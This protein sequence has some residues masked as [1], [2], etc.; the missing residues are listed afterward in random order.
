MGNFALA[1]TFILS[2]V[3]GIGLF[4][5]M[6]ERL[7]N[8]ISDKGYLFNIVDGIIRLVVFFLY[9]IVIS[10]NKNITRVF[11][12]HG[13]E[14]KS[15]HAYEA[16]EELTADNAMKYSPL[17]PRCGTAFLLTVMVVGIIVFSMFGKPDSVLVRIGIRLVFIPLIA[18]FSYEFIKF[19]AKRQ[20]HIFTRIIMTPG[21]WLQRL[22]TREPS[23]DQVQ[24]A[25]VSLKGV[26][27]MEGERVEG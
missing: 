22:T 9:I 10:F 1:I 26:L 21:L 5:I 8:I 11:Q 17:H 20:D 12:Y 18:G 13:A 7:A 14:H 23:I 4:V 25:L 24:V 15:I 16:G 3:F 19:T 27:Q 2:F 6:P